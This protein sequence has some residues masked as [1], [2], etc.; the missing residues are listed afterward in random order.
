MLT[1]HHLIPRKM[2]RRTHFKKRYSKQVLMVGIDLC[3]LCHRGIHKLYNEMTLARKYTIKYAS[4]EKLLA[5][6]EVRKHIEWV[7]K[8][9]RGLAVNSSR[10][11]V[12]EQNISLHDNSG[13]NLS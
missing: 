4:K 1:S 2:H 12:S 5:D 9:K 13:L 8:Q 7:K 11:N 3:Q 6:E 10:R